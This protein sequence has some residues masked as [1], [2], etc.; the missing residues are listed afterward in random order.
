MS[1]GII[2]TTASDQPVPLLHQRDQLLREIRHLAHSNLMRGSLSVVGRKCGRATCACATEGRRHPARY[3]SVKQDGKTRLLYVSA[4]QEA[5]IQVAL[6]R[7]R[8]LM[9]AVDELTQ[10]NLQLIEQARPPRKRRAKQ[11]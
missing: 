10:V 4:G 1:Y 6:R 2:M 5:E 9:A 11:P 3:L 7:C 8:R